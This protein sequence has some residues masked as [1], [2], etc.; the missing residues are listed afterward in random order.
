[1]KKTLLLSASCLL[2][3][4]PFTAFSQSTSAGVVSYQVT[5]QRPGGGGQNAT[6]D[7][8]DDDAG[9]NVFTMNRTFTFNQNAGKLSS[10]D[11]G[12]GRT[13]R[14][15]PSANAGDDNSSNSGGGDNAQS[16][17]GNRMRG[18]GGRGSFRGGR[19][20]NTE[21]V[22]FTDK[23]YIRAFKRGDNDT[24][25]YIAEDY[26]QPENFQKTD[27]TKKIAG[28]TCHKATAQWRNTTYTI[29]YTTDIAANY[30]PINGLT[31]P[32]GGF[33]LDLQSDR[34]EYKATKVDL[35]AVADNE[36]KVPDPS[37]QLSAEQ[38]QAMRQQMRDRMRNRNS[39]SGNQ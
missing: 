31:P 2:A 24:T 20:G 5:M 32:D 7:N 17:R 38:V 23:K 33:V 15:R 9:G 26:T 14:R 34:M 27:K 29:W 35:K 22:D 12:Q 11:F 13:P 4:L 6:A 36:V 25:F 37:E 18:Q 30:S 10:P 16:T 3:A 28:Y 39:Q 21:Y 1:M 19:G 8:S